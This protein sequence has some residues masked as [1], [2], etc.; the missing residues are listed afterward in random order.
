MTN[1]IVS[2]FDDV[3]VK[4]AKE[5]SEEGCCYISAPSPLTSIEEFRNAM[6]EAGIATCD[7]VG[8]PVLM[9]VGLSRHNLK[10]F[11]FRVKTYRNI[12]R[13]NDA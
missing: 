11:E 9:V 13:L 12:E 1:K 10:V 7:E 2:I 4:V 3:G 8:N 6:A 5:M